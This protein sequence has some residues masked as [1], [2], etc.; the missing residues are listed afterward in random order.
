MFRRR[1]SS[2]CAGA[3]RSALIALVAGAFV[4]VAV[5]AVARTRM[6]S[7][8]PV[9][10]ANRPSL[11]LVVGKTGEGA[12]LPVAV[13]EASWTIADKRGLGLDKERIHRQLEARIPGLEI[14]W[15]EEAAWSYA[16][17]PEEVH[18]AELQMS[19]RLTTSPSW[20]ESIR[21]DLL[22]PGNGAGQIR[23]RRRNE[24]VNYVFE[25][26]VEDGRVVPVAY[27]QMTWWDSVYAIGAGLLAAVS[28]LVLFTLV[29]AFS[30]VWFRRRA[31]NGGASS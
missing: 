2:G 15:D 28:T 26:R 1:P 3:F 30:V 5:Y 10:E 12:Y 17:E 25:Y 22:R 24:G 8:E 13:P 20:W 31:R 23:L 16:L 21:L 11:F 4:G 6:A 7:V 27:G 19:D 18:D 9:S 29:Y 14:A